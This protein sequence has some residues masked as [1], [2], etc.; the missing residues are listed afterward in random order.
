MQSTAIQLQ[1][2]H[3]QLPRSSGPQWHISV[4]IFLLKK[5]LKSETLAALGYS[6]FI[7]N[8]RGLKIPGY[9]CNI[10]GIPL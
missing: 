5:I 3:A 8:I 2:H 4:Y 10:N 6:V 1:A 7:K 9:F